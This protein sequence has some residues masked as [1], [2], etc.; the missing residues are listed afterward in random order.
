MQKAEGRRQKEARELALRASAA[1]TS[2]ADVARSS[3]A[4]SLVFRFVCLLPSAFCL[5]L[6]SL[7]VRA[8]AKRL[9]VLKV[10][11]LS[12][13]Q[14]DRFIDERDPR[15]GKSVLPWFRHVFYERGTRAANFYVRG[16]SLSGPSWS[17][18]DT[19]HHLQI[20]A[21]VEFDR[22]TLHSYDYL[23]FIPF[24][25]GHLGRVRVDMPGAELLDELGVPLLYDAY[26]YDE[27]HISFQLYQRGARWTTLE[28][29]LKNRVTTRTKR[30][31]FDEWL[32]EFDSRAILMEQLEREVV[33]KLS[34]PRVRYLDF[35]TTD[36]DHAAHHNRDRATHLAALRELDATVGRL[37]T[38]IQR[39]PLAAETALVLVSDHGTNTDE[40]VYSQGFN[41]VKLLASAAGGGHHVVTKRRLLN[42]Y[43]VKGF[44]PLVPLIHTTTDESLYLKGQSTDYPTALVDF[45][46]NERCAV[47]VRDSDLN[48]LHVLLQ[49]LQDKRLAPQLRPA[50]TDAFFATLDARRADWS[51][52]VAELREELSALERLIEKQ[53]TV[54]AA[55]PKKWTKA[56]ADAGR[57]QAARRLFA[58]IDSWETDVRKYTEYARTLSNLLALRRESF[59]PAGLRIPDLIARGTMGESNTIAELQSYVAGP[60]GGGLALA[61]D[62]SLDLR[63][64]FRR[65]NYFELLRGTTVRNNVQP[66]VANR[67]VDF[68][69]VRV[70]AESMPVSGAE[71]LRADE[72]VWLYRGTDKQAL[73]LSRRARGGRLLIRYLPVAELAQGADGLTRFR[74]VPW[75][76]GLPLEIW[77]DNK[78]RLPAGASREEWLSGWHTDVEWL[79]ALH[80]TRYSNG[81]VGLQEQFARHL[82]PATEPDVP[83][84]TEDERLI[85]R[86]R[87]RQRALVE[88]DLL[89]VA[90]DHWNF[91]VRGFNP[92]GNH[93]SFFRV[94]THSALMFAGGEATGVPRGLVIDEPYDSLSFV[95]TVLTLTGRLPRPEG[96]RP[97]G[98]A[99]S[100]T[101]QFPGR[102]IRELFAPEKPSPAIA[103]SSSGKRTEDEP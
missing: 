71:D 30:E 2:V 26:P 25:L 4:F 53:R 40:R 59:D 12:Q 102:V 92:G 16:M 14:V 62:G 56:D 85:R 57:D 64:S 74:R 19:G 38:A 96:A 79:R 87:R 63:R 49:Q 81:V 88:T 11:G 77:E 83:G 60:A 103:E 13:A 36:F 17:M 15:T 47:H 93:G 94:S 1:F 98:L 3:A 76:A 101:S 33:A 22:L 65:V 6:F 45:D 34:D 70:P 9:V 29:S 42:D 31:L 5:L 69:A 50:A 55:M 89:L 97:V 23:N 35:Y 18:L 37:W 7:P 58:Q 39:S 32:T 28:R 27:R 24:W 52:L 84:L 21:N 8:Q 78:L 41:V 80:L 67:P 100:P 66:G 68:V 10:D 54:H 99:P 73:I 86:L 91:D 48:T 95:P 82:T 51:R 46:G 43:A 20:K 72:V 44:Y 61:A 90:S 75:Q